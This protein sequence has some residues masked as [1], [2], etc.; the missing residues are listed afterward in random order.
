VAQT[1]KHRKAALR[2]FVK[3]YLSFNPTADVDKESMGL[4]LYNATHSPILARPLTLKTMEA[5][6]F[7]TKSGVSCTAFTA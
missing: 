7:Q 2:T 4:P 6:V 3:T 5:A 1:G